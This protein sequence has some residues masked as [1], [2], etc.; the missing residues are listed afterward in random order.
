MK[1]IFYTFTALLLAVSLPSKAQTDSGT[2]QKSEKKKE[3]NDGEYIPKNIIKTN[4]LGIPLRNYTLQYERVLTRRFSAQLEYRFMPDGHLPLS[5]FIPTGEN[6][7]VQESLK[8]TTFSA[9]AITPSIKFYPT[10]KGYGRGFYITA[11]YRATNYS[12]SNFKYVYDEENNNS[13]TLK[14]D[15]KTN[16]FGVGI[17][18]QWT[19]GK[20]I[21]LDYTIFGLQYGSASGN[22]VGNYTEDLSAE[23]Q[24]KVQDVLDGIELPFV[25]TK[26][27]VGTNRTTIKIDGPWAMLRT[28]F[29]IGVRF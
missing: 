15:F 26:V 1:T 8:N 9:T 11:N 22:F 5:Q 3:S 18:K 20:F 16:T 23:D 2:E 7:D 24:Q 27:N 13:V 10:R 12:A 6:G 29:S 14:G 25:T 17:G 4:L 19:V 28:G 21:V